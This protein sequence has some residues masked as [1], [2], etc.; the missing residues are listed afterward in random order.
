MTLAGSLVSPSP[1][2][3]LVSMPFHRLTMPPIGLGILKSALNAAGLRATVWNLGL[4]L[5]PEL[6]ET[7]AEALSRY[8]LLG[9]DLSNELAGEWF[10]APPDE[11]RDARYLALLP[12]RGFEPGFQELLPRLR[13]RVDGFLRR[14]ARRIVEAGCDVV[15]FSAA[16]SRTWANARLAGAIREIAP[17]TRFLIGGYEASGDMGCALLE[18]F[19]VIDLACHTE[20]DDLIVPLVRALRGEEGQ[21]LSALRGISY[22]EGDRIVCHKDGAPLPDV[23]RVPLPDYQDYFEQ[24]EPLRARWGDALDL[25][26]WVPVETARGCWWGEHR[27]C[28]FCSYASERMAFRTKSPERVLGDLAAL[29]T[30][31]GVTRFMAV[32]N[33]LGTD[34]FKTLLPRLAETRAGYS[35]HWEVR[36]TLRRE[37]AAALARAGVVHAFLGIESLASPALRLMRKGT[38]SLD[39]I[40][41]LKWL[42]AF[43]VRCTWHFLFS[44]P[45]ER[46]EW[47]EEVARLVPRLM[48][49]QPPRGPIRIAMQRF[50]PFFETARESGVRL[51]GPAL[52]ARLAFDGV[53]D[54]LLERLTSTFE[55]EIGGRPE[56]L[57]RG[58]AELLGPLLDRWRRRFE[59]KG[60]TLSWIDGPGESLLVEGPLLEPDRILRVR[61]LLRS[62]LQGCA[63]ALPERL[64]LERLASGAGPAGEPEPPLGPRAYRDVLEE[65]SF[66]G[67]RPDEAP[68]VA[69]GDLVTVA[70]G[71]GWVVREAGRILSL[72]VDR[73]KHVKSGPFQLEAALRRFTASQP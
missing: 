19:P 54:D 20:A 62:F 52:F 44:L 40:E 5:L 35:F 53:R 69:L 27:H 43:D 64:L 22:R 60:C 71:R 23:E 58:I 39:G 56:G 50:S 42:M 30:R 47:Y 59:E 17:A 9:D 18:A 73:T 36:P 15:G 21:A 63:S 33:I 41:A 38:S 10:F 25:P 49:L 11:E 37:G 29:R 6:G 8:E 31:Y 3:A 46:L 24:L 32:D 1:V 45:G 7:A 34:Y 66:P 57:D 61:G 14:T 12:D 2:V 4:D 51:L 72:P 70:E 26:R 48:H 67:A 13:S 28:V 65:L 55:H 16:Y 68:D